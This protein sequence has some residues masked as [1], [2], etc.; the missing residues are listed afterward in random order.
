MHSYAGK[1]EDSQDDPI[2]CDVRDAEVRADNLAV[3][4]R[5]I[6]HRERWDPRGTSQATP[7]FL[8]IDNNQR[9]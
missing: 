2:R 4:G 9:G 8:N 6:V 1:S 5:E 3:Y 7:A